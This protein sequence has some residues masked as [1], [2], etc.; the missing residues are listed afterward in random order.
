MLRLV[1]SEL[2]IPPSWLALT[3]ATLWVG[4]AL[5]TIESQELDGE[6]A[7]GAK[8]FGLFEPEVPSMTVKMV[9][10]KFRQKAAKP[11]GSAKLIVD[12]VKRG[13]IGKTRK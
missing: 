5:L 10:C 1:M 4:V 11:L 13:S 2:Q 3:V 7:N 9:S 8:T 6:V 12:L